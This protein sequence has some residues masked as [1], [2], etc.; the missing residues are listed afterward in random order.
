M[1][2]SLASNIK[3]RRQWAI[4][5]ACV[6]YQCRPRVN[7]FDGACERAVGTGSRYTGWEWVDIRW[8][9]IW[10]GWRQIWKSSLMPSDQRTP[11][12]EKQCVLVCG[13]NCG[14]NGRIVHHILNACVCVCLCVWVSMWGYR[15]NLLGKV[16]E[17]RDPS[18]GLC[19]AYVK[20]IAK[21]SEPTEW[22]NISCT[23]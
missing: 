20:C 16:Q 18:K 15:I 11:S 4:D 1:S 12:K 3:C 22:P 10:G 5:F 13:L 19:T 21:P 2:F 17:R 8:D 23:T 9:L 14:V 7:K 6:C